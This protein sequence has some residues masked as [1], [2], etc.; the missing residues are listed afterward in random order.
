[1]YKYI[2]CPP[3][4]KEFRIKL[5]ADRDKAMAFKKEVGGEFLNFNNTKHKDKY[6]AELELSEGFFDPEEAKVFPYCISWFNEE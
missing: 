6:I 3:E 5:F 2:G 1:M 4:E